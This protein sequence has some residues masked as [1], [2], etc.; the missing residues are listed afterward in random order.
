MVSWCFFFLSL[1]S[2]IP[3]AKH[4]KNARHQNGMY[5]VGKRDNFF[6]ITGP[7]SR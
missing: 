5:A 7:L 4:T 2:K 6:P 3:S 1:K